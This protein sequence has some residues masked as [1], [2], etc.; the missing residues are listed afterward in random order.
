MSVIH[1]RPHKL[2]GANREMEDRENANPTICVRYHNSQ[3]PSLTP[4]MRSKDKEAAGKCSE[5][6]LSVL[7]ALI[8]RLGTK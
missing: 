2:L 4:E 7:I 3:S 8:L 1:S 6:A 5:D